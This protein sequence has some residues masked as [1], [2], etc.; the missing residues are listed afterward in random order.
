MLRQWWELT[1]NE[2]VKRLNTVTDGIYSATSGY[3]N[4]LFRHHRLS[5]HES[6]I[7]HGHKV[8]DRHPSCTQ[9]LLLPLKVPHYILNTEDWEPLICPFNVDFIC[10]YFNRERD[11]RTT[12]KSY[13][14][15]RWCYTYISSWNTTKSVIWRTYKV[16]R[17][18]FGQSNFKRNSYI[19]DCS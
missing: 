12:M 15:K 16:Y 11:H 5:E 14:V 4:N 1:E 13:Y 17:V 3:S 8:H 9:K 7:F 2:C 6:D 18:L 19:I 10:I